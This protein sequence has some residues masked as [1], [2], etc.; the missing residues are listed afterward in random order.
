VNASKGH[1]W[2]DFGEYILPYAPVIR[3]QHPI[4]GPVQE[5]ATFRDDIVI[6]PFMREDKI[7]SINLW[8]SHGPGASV[9][10]CEPNAMANLNVQ[11]RGKKHVW[12]FSP[13][14]A[15]CLSVQSAVME[16]PFVASEVA[17]EAV[18][19]A[20]APFRDARC[21]ETII[22]EGDA[23]F[24]PPFW[25]HWFVHYPVF[26]LN[27]NFWWEPDQIP[28][29]PISGEWMFMSALCKALGGFDT[30][31]EE[32]ARLPEETKALLRRIERQL[33]DDVS[34]KS[35]LAMLKLRAQMQIAR[36]P[37]PKTGKY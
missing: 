33:I 29:S 31:V 30:A 8:T 6:P 5:M 4:T 27:M 22:E 13:D 9:N 34:L 12:L 10:H 24:I 36:V 16:P 14:D 1:N 20:H 32:F 25:F 15:K 17:P 11:I 19:T 2:E 28:L 21:F 7:S 35:S 3:I 37:D 23:V 26:Q 18:S